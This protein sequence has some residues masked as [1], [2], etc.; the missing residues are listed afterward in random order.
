MSEIFSIDVGDILRLM[1]R[2]R[3]SDTVDTLSDLD[4]SNERRRR[5]IES[6]LFSRRFIL[7]YNIVLVGLL[8]CFTAWY[9]GS[10][11][12]RLRRRRHAFSRSPPSQPTASNLI[13]KDDNEGETIPLLSQRKVHVDRHKKVSAVAS[14]RA[15][16][17]YQPSN[18]PYVH[19]V[20]PSNITTIG[21]LIL[22]GINLFFLLYKAELSVATAFIFADRAGL[23]FVANLPLLYLLAAKN[24]PLKVLTDASYEGLNIFHRRLGEWMCLLALLHA[25]SMVLVWYTTLSTRLSFSRFLALPIIW[26]GLLAFLSY[27]TLY[28]SSLGSFRK[29]CYEVFLGLHIILQVAALAFLWFHHHNS[30]PYVLVALCIFAV[31]RLIFRLILKSRTVKADLSVLQDEETVMLSSNW[32]LPRSPWWRSFGIKEGWK[33]A[34]HVFLTVP[35]LSHKHFVQAHPFTIASAA[36]TSADSH[37]WLNFL[38]RAQDGFSRDLLRYAEFHSSVKIRVD[39]PY[40][41]S[42]ALDMLHDNE[43]AVVVAGGSGIAVAF[44]L[45]WSLLTASSRDPEPESNRQ[46]KSRVSL[47]WVVHDKEHIDWISQDRLDELRE[48]GCS[49]MIPPPTRKTGRPDLPHLLETAVN[50]WSHEIADPRVGVVV[51]GPD[52][53]NRSCRNVC[54]SLVSQGTRLE[55]SVEK[56]GW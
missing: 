18:I 5:A 50:A 33:P 51:A 39:G 15:W 7:I 6:I 45:V 24:Q 38:I 27:E 20:L 29:K 28:L 22:L 26:L 16:L 37:A 10:R 23:L 2:A 19:K 47:I 35:A 32:Q 41:S 31:D 14:V 17:M 30:Q 25:G 54:A 8:A 21:I 46:S 53:M 43:V 3:A 52:G 4:N 42:H 12:A 13:R 49:V 56:F 40:G 44:P 36:P 11:V 48:L 55:I 1:L 9:W 34:E